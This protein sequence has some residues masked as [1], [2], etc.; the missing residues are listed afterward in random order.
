MDLKHF[1][2]LAALAADH[3][4][5]LEVKLK[6]ART[7]RK[8]LKR[9]VNEAITTIDRRAEEDKE[10][11]SALFMSLITEEELAIIELCEELDIP[12]ETTPNI[13]VAEQDS[14][15]VAEVTQSVSAI[16]PDITPVTKLVND[17]RKPSNN[18]RPH[19]I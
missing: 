18:R 8:N 5:Q 7:I 13:F 19:V 15:H 1:D 16:L 6:N 9:M 14:K 12:K 11:I 2:N 4:M 10:S 17:K 3:R